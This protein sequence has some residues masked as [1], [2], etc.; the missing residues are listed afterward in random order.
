ML[1]RYHPDSAVPRPSARTTKPRIDRDRA[2]RIARELLVG[3]A[4]VLMLTLDHSLAGGVIATKLGTICTTW[5]KPVYL[6]VLGFIV[7]VRLFIGGIAIV[8]EENNGGRIIGVAVIGGLLG[9][10]LPAALLALIAI[11]GGFNC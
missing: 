3:A 1:E 6:G 11:G 9:V 5:V 2:A 8:Q 4:A 7:L 10:A